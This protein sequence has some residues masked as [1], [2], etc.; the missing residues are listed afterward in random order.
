MKCYNK[1]KK[2]FE[3]IIRIRTFGALLDLSVNNQKR[4]LLIQTKNRNF[5]SLKMK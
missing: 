3:K 2:Y 5:A 1:M 4:N